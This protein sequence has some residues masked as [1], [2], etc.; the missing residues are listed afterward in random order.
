[1]FFKKKSPLAFILTGFEHSGTTLVSE[2]MRQ[3]PDIDSG[4]EGGLLLC[5]KISDFE[6]LEPFASN[7]KNA[8]GIKDP[9]F[10]DICKSRNY[11]EAYEKIRLYSASIPNKKNKIFDK[12]PRYLQKFPEVLARVPGVNAV[13]IV[14]DMRAI[15]DSTFRRSGK[16]LNEWMET[17]YPVT[18]KHTRSY[19][20]GLSKALNINKYK[21]RILVIRYEQ[22]MLEQ[23]DVS[24]AVFKHLDFKFNNDY[25][26][27]DSVKYRHVYG[28]DI[29][30][31]YIYKFREN[32]TDDVQGKIKSDFADYSE[33]FWDV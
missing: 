10:V 23:E 33:Y 4:F 28:N 13:V 18:L 16:E 20:N 26:H 31:Q 27:F 2:I 30:D 6:K 7:F 11:S 25:L 17:T 32:L 12:T 14:R 29:Q 22:L 9:D 3:H 15:I 24:K 19:L 1:M 21:K 8:W 5:N